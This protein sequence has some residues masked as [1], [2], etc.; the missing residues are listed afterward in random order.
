MVINKSVSYTHLDVYK[1]Q[2]LCMLGICW[3]L[4]VLFSGVDKVG[5][6]VGQVF[7]ALENPGVAQRKEEYSGYS[8]L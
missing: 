3:L 1:R 4:L 6:E 5:S 7:A 2:V 8:V